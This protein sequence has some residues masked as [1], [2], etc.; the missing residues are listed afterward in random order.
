MYASTMIRNLKRLVARFRGNTSYPFLGSQLYWEERYLSGGNSGDGS[1]GDL[2]KYKAEY[3]SEL[4][5]LYKIS[6]VVE[7]GCGDGNQLGLIQYSNYTGLDISA[8]AIDKCRSKYLDNPNFTFELVSNFLGGKFDLAMSLDVIYHLVE[9]SVYEEHMSS[10]FNSA[11]RFV[12]IYSSNFDSP[13]IEHVRHRFFTDWV[14]NLA[15]EFEL[16]AYQPNPYTASNP[17]NKGNKS[18]ADFFLFQRK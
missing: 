12:L 1:Y 7:F 6:S 5:K 15:P 14:R 4:L 13:S 9:D 17:A 8:S 10:L 3:I 2:A 11:S 18:S 16:V